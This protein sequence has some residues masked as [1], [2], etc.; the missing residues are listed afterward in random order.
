MEN[1]VESETGS[2]SAEDNIVSNDDAAVITNDNN[3]PEVIEGI[4]SI[5]TKRKLPKTVCLF[6]KTKIKKWYKNLY[7]WANWQYN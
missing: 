5:G 4:E 3:N 1:P 2:K 7:S 6:P